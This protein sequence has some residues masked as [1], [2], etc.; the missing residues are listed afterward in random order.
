MC[1]LLKI[2]TRMVNESLTIS[3]F[4]N[5]ILYFFPNLF[6]L[7]ELKTKIFVLFVHLY[8]TMLLKRYYFIQ[9]FLF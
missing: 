1:L 3:A 4:F 8:I 9:S 6:G 2:R 7:F 5:I